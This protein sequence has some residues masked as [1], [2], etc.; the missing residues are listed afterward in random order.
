MTFIFD[1]E[2]E[3]EKRLELDY[4]SEQTQ[5]KK[6]TANKDY[7]IESQSDFPDVE[8]FVTDV[9][10]STLDVTDSGMTVPIVGE[11]NTIETFNASY[12]SNIKLFQI[13]MVLGKKDS[14]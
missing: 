13:S 2:L 5:N 3:T 12:N 1:K 14:I 10:F 4:Y 6:L 7:R 11:Y 9:H 8:D